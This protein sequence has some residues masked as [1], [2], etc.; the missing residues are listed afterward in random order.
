MKNVISLDADIGNVLSQEQY[1]KM[2]IVSKNLAD[3][4]TR[5]NTDIVLFFSADTSV[6]TPLDDY[7][8]YAVWFCEG[9]DELL[10]FAISQTCNN[11]EELDYYLQRRKKQI[12]YLLGADLFAPYYQRYYDYAPIGFLSAESAQYIREK[13]I[14]LLFKS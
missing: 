12:N 9:I 6:F 1:F 10:N 4:N 2:G 8:E 5:F 11:V 3:F 14:D 13:L 7:D